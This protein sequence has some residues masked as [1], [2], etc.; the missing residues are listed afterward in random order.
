MIKVAGTENTYQDNNQKFT[1]VVDI[2]DSDHTKTIKSLTG[3]GISG[4][5][6]ATDTPD[7]LAL[8]NF[9]FDDTL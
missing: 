4:A 1:V 5:V 7:F 3:P 9:I 6:S 8:M 2:N